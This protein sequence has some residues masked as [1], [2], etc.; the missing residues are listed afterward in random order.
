MDLLD[1]AMTLNQESGGGPKQVLGG[2]YS[3]NCTTRQKM[4]L[5]G[6]FEADLW[7]KGKK[8]THPV[9]VINKLNDNIIGI[10][11]I[12]AHKHTYDVH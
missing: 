3:L 7:V 12:H 6:I 5:L 1:L 11:F 9:N 4:S 8:F 2:I 10:V